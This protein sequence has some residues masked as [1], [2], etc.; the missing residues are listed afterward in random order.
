MPHPGI[1][2]H[3]LP[4]GGDGAGLLFVIGVGVMILLSLPQ[5]RV[6][7]ALS[8]PVGLIIG[9]ILRLTSRD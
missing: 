3:K 8:L 5:A 7:L 1:N 4:V 9:V 6:F 2:M